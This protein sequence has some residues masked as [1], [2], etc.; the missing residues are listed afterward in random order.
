MK[1][2]ER[3]CGIIEYKG[4]GM[5]WQEREQEGKRNENTARVWIREDK[6]GCVQEQQVGT[7]PERI[8]SGQRQKERERVHT[9]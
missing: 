6:K 1:E 9:K 7:N 5:K 8:P 3:Q 2:R 4:K